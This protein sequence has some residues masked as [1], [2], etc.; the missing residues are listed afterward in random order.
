MAYAYLGAFR[1]ALHHGIRGLGEPSLLQL[2]PQNGGMEIL[3][4]ISPT[5]IKTRFVPLPNLELPARF[6]RSRHSRRKLPNFVWQP[7]SGRC[8]PNS[9]HWLQLPQWRLC[10]GSRRCMAAHF[11][12]PNESFG[13]GATVTNGRFGGA[14]FQRGLAARRIDQDRV[15]VG[16]S[17]RSPR[18]EG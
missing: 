13:P 15:R 16:R 17:R 1:V 7:A 8:T 5:R 10:G 11:L 3:F 14:R 4:G 18:A 2:E 9:G 6:L 12:V